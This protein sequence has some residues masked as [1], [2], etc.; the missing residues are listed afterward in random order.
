[1]KNSSRTDRFFQFLEKRWQVFISLTILALFWG[2][3]EQEPLK[4]LL[5]PHRSFFELLTLVFGPPI[6]AVGFYLGYRAKR[7]MVSI[8]GSSTSTLVSLANE[9]SQK[10]ALAT[11]LEESSKIE[12]AQLAR[13]R[14]EL[15]ERTAQLS[16]ER[17]RVE[18][19]DANLRR[20]TD[21]GH[22]L[23][24][25]TPARPFASYYEWMR[26]PRGAQI[27][28]IG[29][30]KGG[31]GKTT[32]AANLA[33]YFSQHR[34]LPVLL[35]DLDYQGSLSNMMMY[36][37]GFEDVPSNVDAL[38][39]KQATLETLSNATVHLHRKLPQAWL[40]PAS[41]SLGS[42]ESRLLL[43]WL[44]DPEPGVDARYR[45][46]QLLL[47][48]SVRQRYSVIILDMPPRMT[49]GAVNALVA[50]HHLI[51]PTIFD[52]LS[53]EAVRQFLTTSHAIKT[54]LKLDLDLLAIIGCMSRQLTLSPREDL[55]WKNIATA[56]SAWGDKDY[57]TARTI[58][59]RSTIAEAAGQ[60]LAYQ[61]NREIFEPL[62][63]EIWERL[64]RRNVPS[65]VDTRSPH[66]TEQV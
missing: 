51:V 1:M 9:L 60:D 7:D 27:I 5:A 32:I 65:L 42:T 47:N 50:S 26:D 63:D 11:R 31:V 12:G 56:S 33:A 10:T 66:E 24:K 59:L 49:L 19:L 39:T 23:W 48:P 64:Q 57:R 58:P 38:F 54:D 45:L 34:E 2:W 17:I 36:A 43:D 18:K 55:A 15:D 13:T 25:A 16:A 4:R 20:V 3:W 35:I 14:H 52:N 8:Q 21:G 40:V 28:T 53:V 29:N 61:S 41:Y 44:M 46:A 30:L 22:D 62:G 6:T 37:A